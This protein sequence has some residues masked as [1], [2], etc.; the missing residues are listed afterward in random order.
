[1]KN[2]ANENPERAKR[3]ACPAAPDTMVPKGQNFGH[4]IIEIT[5]W[6]IPTSTALKNLQTTKHHYSKEHERQ[7]EEC[8]PPA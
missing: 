4:S 7:N 2:E 1:M 8:P 3:T 5:N 6:N